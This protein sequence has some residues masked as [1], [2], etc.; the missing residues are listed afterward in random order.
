MY[1]VHELRRIRSAVVGLAIVVI[2]CTTGILLAMWNPGLMLGVLLVLGLM[3]GVILIT[4]VIASIVGNT[5][6]KIMTRI[7]NKNEKRVSL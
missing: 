5:T 6:L 7:R 1:I 2:L 4:C 3:F